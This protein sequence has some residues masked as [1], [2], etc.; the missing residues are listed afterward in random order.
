M[1]YVDLCQQNNVFAFKYAVYFC[2]NFPSKEQVLSNFMAAVTTRIDFG[3][4]SCFL[5]LVSWP[6][7]ESIPV[8][9]L[10][11]SSFIDSRVYVLKQ[12]QMA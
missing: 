6:Q 9:F 8:S 3:G 5:F 1:T 4:Y 12:N 2:H 10:S 11:Q 7:S